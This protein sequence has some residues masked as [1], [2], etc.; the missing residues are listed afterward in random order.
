MTA[1]RTTIVSISF[2]L[3]AAASAMAGSPLA[4][5][6]TGTIGVGAVEIGISGSHTRDREASTKTAATDAELSV[7]T[8]LCKNL[9]VSLAVPYL[10]GERVKEYGVL[11]VKTEGFGDMT[12]ELKY[13]IAEL[14]GVNIAIKPAVNIPSS[15]SDLTENHWQYGVTLIATKELEN[16]KYALHA[17]LGYEHHTYDN[18]VAGIRGNLWSG[19][20][21]G[22]AELV[23]GLFAVAEFGLAT[24]PEEGV[25]TLP[26]HALTGV[27][28]EI[29]N[30]F[31]VSAGI[32][33]GLTSPEDD[34]S[35]L[36]GL[37]LKF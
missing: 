8:G 22:E 36:Y 32:K 35:A 14:S 3:M 18:D 6:D 24:N 37:V 20:V 34:F 11:S 4:T 12:V 5:D 13:G 1:L 19:S 7:G 23:K 33:L 21:A 25:H 27:R 2:V 31:E 10:I 28:Y 30:Y 15:K 17:N 29:N 16:G 26:V 9:S